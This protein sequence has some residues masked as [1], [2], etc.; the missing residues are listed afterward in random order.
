MQDNV[1]TQD[2]NEQANEQEEILK[3]MAVMIL[4][5]LQKIYEQKGNKIITVQHKN[6]LV[7][8][9]KGAPVDRKGWFWLPYLK[10][11][12]M[13]FQPEEIA[14]GVKVY[15]LTPDFF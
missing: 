13:E 15:H 12:S 14:D 5:K 6:N 9:S 8:D 11:F 3:I 10:D 1:I 7:R 4:K 2:L